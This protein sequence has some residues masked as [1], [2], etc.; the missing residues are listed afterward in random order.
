MTF[1]LARTW[2]V[3]AVTMLMVVTAGCSSENPEGDPQGEVLVAEETTD[4][5]ATTDETEAADVEQPE[6]EEPAGH[7]VPTEHLEGALV[8]SFPADVPLYDGHI[9]DSLSDISEFSGAPEWNVMISTPDSVDAVGASV[10]E[11][12]ST[13]GWSMGSEMESAGGYLF[14]ARGAGYTV[15]VSYNDAF[16]PD[17][18]INYGVSADG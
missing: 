2:T 4:V 5:T 14:T 10:R 11:A 17:T 8:S 12:Y 16:G 1:R 3:A 6:Q 7:D 15:S 13:N 18:T 9:V